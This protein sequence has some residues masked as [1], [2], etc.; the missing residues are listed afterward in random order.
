MTDAKKPRILLI[1]D[2]PGWIFERHAKT[3]QAHLAD[4]L[5]IDVAYL[6]DEF[7]EAAY[8]LV[9]PLEWYLVPEGMPRQPWKWVTGIRSHSSWEGRDLPALC[10]LLRARFSRIYAVSAR[11]QALFRD[12]LPGLALLPHGVDTGHFRPSG[13]PP[14]PG[15][16]LRVGWAGNRKV[17]VKGFEEFIRPLGELPGVRLV[18]C[19]YSDRLLSFDEMRAFYESIDVYVCSSLSEGHNNSLMEAAAMERAIVTTDVGTVPEYL[20]DGQSA[21]IVAREPGAFRQAIERLRGDP[22]LRARL[23]SAARKAV[24][25][26]YPW[27]A[28]LKDYRNFMMEAL[29]LARPAPGPEVFVLPEG[30]PRALVVEAAAAFYHA[31][32]AADPVTLVVPDGGGGENRLLVA[33]LAPPPGR[34]APPSIQVLEAPSGT[35]SARA[36]ANSHAVGPVP[37]TA[38]VPDGARSLAFNQAREWIRG[39]RL[40]PVLAQ[41]DALDTAVGRIHASGRLEAIVC[42]AAPLG[43]LAAKRLRRRGIEVLAIT[44][45]TASRHSPPLD[46]IPVLPLETALALAPAA[47]LVTALASGPA[48]EQ[49][50]LSLCG[51]KEVNPPAIFRVMIS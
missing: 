30:S 35:P 6:G 22:E 10:Q 40:D 16:E 15:S 49:E 42:G 26:H 20:Q 7:D 33:F 19:G 47:A 5:D 46:G 11:L 1:A 34:D 36:F 31:F 27:Q 2:C 3:L 50:I 32:T 4:E 48:V 39:H 14:A 23:G 28:R 41:L 24:L 51:G 25:A 9:H 8:D 13:P 18:F 43:R 12:G 37:E 21:L 29:A 17:A 38:P 45:R 44:D